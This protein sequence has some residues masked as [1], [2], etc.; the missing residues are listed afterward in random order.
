MVVSSIGS[1]D[2][3]GQA[4]TSKIGF[5]VIQV[6]GN[7]VISAGQSNGPTDPGVQVL[8]HCRV[9]SGGKLSFTMKSHS[10][11]LITKLEQELLPT[12]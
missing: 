10:L 4:L 5:S 12:L 6:I 1:A 3:Y 7:E 9:E 2:A 11:N 8:I